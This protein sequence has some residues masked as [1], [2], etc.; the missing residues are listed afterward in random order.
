M[1]WTICQSNSRLMV[2]YSIINVKFQQDQEAQR[3]QEGEAVR[4]VG[5]AAETKSLQSV[6]QDYALPAGVF[7]INIS[8]RIRL[9][10]H[11]EPR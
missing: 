2:E 11:Q 4:T 1:F 6:H 7:H 8:Q 3:E 10:R 5:D 9:L